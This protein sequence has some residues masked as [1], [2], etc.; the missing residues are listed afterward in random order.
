MDFITG[1][2][3][4]SGV[5]NS[6]LDA[7]SGTTKLIYDDIKRVYGQISHAHFQSAESALQSSINSSNYSLELLSAVGHL[8]DSYYVAKADTNKEKKSLIFFTTPMYKDYEIFQIGRNLIRISTIIA[9]IYNIL[10]EEKNALIW[11]DR[12]FEDYRLYIS[13]PI[14]QIIS[15]YNDKKFSH[16]HGTQ[17]LSAIGKLGDHNFKIGKDYSILSSHYSSDICLTKDGVDRLVIIRDTYHTHLV[18]AFS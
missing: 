16:L 1:I 4:A 13:N 9:Q 14:D 6:I 10:G 2:W 12:S 7:L 18:D 8:R 15:R 5:G 11:K 3:K 17:L